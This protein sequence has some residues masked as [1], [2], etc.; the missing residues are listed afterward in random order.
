M[1]KPVFL[2]VMLTVLI[3]SAG[4]GKNP[5]LTGKVYYIDDN[6]PVTRGTVIF[7]SSGYTGRAQIE[8]DG[9]YSVHSESEGYGLPPGTYKVYLDAT[10][11]VTVEGGGVKL[12]NMVAKK[13]TRPDTS[14]LEL[15]VNKS[16]TFDIPVERFSRE[17]Q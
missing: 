15:T 17:T 4:C 5:K 2:I 6:S 8:K 3:L 14:G 12:E 10:E 7:L 9:S 13:Y 16:Q 11:K 1:H